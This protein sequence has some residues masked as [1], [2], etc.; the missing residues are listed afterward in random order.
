MLLFRSTRAARRSGLG[1][2]ARSLLL[3][4]GALSFAAAVTGCRIK[5]PS[6]C[7]MPALC[8]PVVTPDPFAG[9]QCVPPKGIDP[10]HYG[11]VATQWRVLGQREPLCCAPPAPVEAESA[12]PVEPLP[13]PP[14]P[15]AAPEIAPEPPDELSLSAYFAEEETGSR[16]YLTDGIT[17]P[18]KTESGCR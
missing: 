3:L 17:R 1:Q 6:R 5:T 12:A 18:R 14:D 7:G 4:T 13:V 15:E 8:A 11:Y 10:G 16:V 9:D 2:P